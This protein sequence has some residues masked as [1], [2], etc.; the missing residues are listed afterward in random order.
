PTRPTFE[1]KAE[2]LKNPFYELALPNAV[3][4]F[5]QGFGRLIRS[6]TDRGIVFV[7]DARIKKSTYG[8]NFIKSIPEIPVIF[9]SIKELIYIYIKSFITSIPKIPVIYDSTKELIDISRK[10]F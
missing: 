7:C 6:S 2:R 3:L 9:D 10:W 8:K 5:K 1:A 4:R